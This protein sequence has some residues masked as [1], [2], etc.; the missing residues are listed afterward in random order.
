MQ[1]EAAA[2]QAHVDAGG[3]ALVTTRL[4]PLPARHNSADNINS[5][6]ISTLMSSGGRPQ[7]PHEADENSLVTVSGQTMDVRTAASLGLIKLDANGKIE[8]AAEGATSEAPVKQD[9]NAEEDFGIDRSGLDFHIME[10][11]PGKSLRDE[12]R[13]STVLFSCRIFVPV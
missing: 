2:K 13:T 10:Q 5:D 4:G 11:M 8:G 6:P 12:L 7:L 3:P 9:D 1:A